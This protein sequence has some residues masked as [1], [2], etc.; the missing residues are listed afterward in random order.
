MHLKSCFSFAGCVDQ[1]CS[2]WDIPGVSSYRAAS[3]KDGEDRVSKNTLVKGQFHLRFN[4]AHRA[5]WPFHSNYTLSFSLE[6]LSPSAWALKPTATAAQEEAMQE[7]EK[8]E[9]QSQSVARLWVMQRVLPQKILP[10]F[11]S[12]EQHK[13]AGVWR[14]HASFL[15]LD[16]KTNF[17]WWSWQR[18]CSC[19]I[20]DYTSLQ[21]AATAEWSPVLFFFSFKVEAKMKH[22]AE[23]H[24]FCHVKDISVTTDTSAGLKLGWDTNQTHRGIKR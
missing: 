18:T 14:W 11:I 21:T 8:Q 13:C 20:S 5:A 12:R 24:A 10:A 17:K 3:R 1:F 7:F 16:T 19:L 9:N 23:Q 4:S 2:C 6:W 22:S 15:C